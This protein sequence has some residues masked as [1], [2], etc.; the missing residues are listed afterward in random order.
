[1][2]YMDTPPYRILAHKDANFAT[3]QRMVRFARYWDLIGNSGRFPN[4]L[5]I[6]LA[7]QPFKYFMALSDW[8]FNT[9][10]QTHRIALPKLFGLICKHLE[11]VRALPA[12]DIHESL[13]IDHRHNKLKGVPGFARQVSPDR[14]KEKPLITTTSESSSASRSAAA[15]QQRHTG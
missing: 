14:I 13:L 5:P 8:L 12:S 10:A 3:V 7:D 2:R 4:T 6:I 1:M 11:E 15:R 9:T